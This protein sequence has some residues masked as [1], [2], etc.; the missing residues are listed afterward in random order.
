MAGSVAAG[1]ARTGVGP[2]G[3]AA[4][5]GAVSP[6]QGSRSVVGDMRHHIV[7]YWVSWQWEWPRFGGFMVVGSEAAS[8]KLVLQSCPS[9]LTGR[10]YQPTPAPVPAYSM[11]R[12]LGTW[13]WP[14]H[15][16]SSGP[17]GAL[18]SVLQ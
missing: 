14:E 4:R 7:G 11:L 10:D 9:S 12:Y 1:L 13:V 16:R 5:A 18:Q 3:P 17:L 6:Q 2:G 8:S 15:L